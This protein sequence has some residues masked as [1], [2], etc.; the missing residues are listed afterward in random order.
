LVLEAILQNLARNCAHKM[1]T[2]SHESGLGVPGSNLSHE[3][4]NVQQMLPFSRI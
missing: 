3:Y 4:Y 2:E 1:V